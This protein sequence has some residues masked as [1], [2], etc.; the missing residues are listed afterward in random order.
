MKKRYIPGRS[1]SRVGW[2]VGRSVS[3]SVD[4]RDQSKEHKEMQTVF[5]KTKRVGQDRAHW[6]YGF[7]D[8]V[9]IREKCKN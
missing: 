3:Q 8:C 7:Y 5:R 9:E 1:R 2:L 6:E 4:Q